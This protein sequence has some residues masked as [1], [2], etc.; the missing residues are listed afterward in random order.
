MLFA[1]ERKTSKVCL[2][3]LFFDFIFLFRVLFSEEKLLFFQKREKDFLIKNVLLVIIRFYKLASFM[4]SCLYNDVIT[5]LD[6]R[7]LQ[8]NEINTE[9]ILLSVF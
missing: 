2:A 4:F 7:F 6:Q 8:Y 5:T 9:D 1:P 3:L